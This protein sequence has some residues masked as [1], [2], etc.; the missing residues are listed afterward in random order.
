MVAEIDYFKK[1]KVHFQQR[2]ISATL[3]SYEKAIEHLHNKKEHKK[4]ILEF[5]ARS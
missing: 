1:S 5:L 3:E 2:D 4:E